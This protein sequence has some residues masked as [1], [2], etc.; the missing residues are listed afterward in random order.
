MT[1][2]KC[3]ADLRMEYGVK[4][5][6]RAIPNWDKDERLGAHVIIAH[7]VQSVGDSSEVNNMDRGL[8][9]EYPKA[10]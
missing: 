1:S 9:Y 8:S 6:M 3:E 2:P 7:L 10:S 4:A 5:T